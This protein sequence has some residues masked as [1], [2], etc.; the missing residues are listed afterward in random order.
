MLFVGNWRLNCLQSPLDGITMG[1]PESPTFLFG[2]VPPPQDR[3]TDNGVFDSE[4][5][6][7]FPRLV[8]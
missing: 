3:V 6:G 7:H 1:H 5:I 2:D 8:F 4:A